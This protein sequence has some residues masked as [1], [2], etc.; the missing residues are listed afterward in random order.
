VTSTVAA[1]TLLGAGLVTP[2]QFYQGLSER[3]EDFRSRPAH[4]WQSPEESS[5]D[6]WYDKYPDYGSGDRSVSYYTSGELV[7]Y[8][9]DLQMR[10]RSQGTK[11]IRD[12]FLWMNDNYAR[13]GTLF[14]QNGIE[15]AAK[16]VI[17]DE[18]S[19]F[20]AANVGHA[21]DLPLEET[22]A[23]AGLKL[24]RMKINTSDPGISVARNSD[25]S[26]VI[27]RV[28][29]ASAWDAG[30]REGD[31]VVEFEGQ[32]VPRRLQSR[33][34]SFPPGAQI[35]LKVRRAGQETA[36]TIPVESRQT[37]RWQISESPNASVKQLARR[38]AW[39]AQ[40]D[41]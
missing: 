9:L 24:E 21:S 35:H 16:R 10:E 6:T 11:G 37:E 3:I 12:L 15:N 14:A 28:S 41:E 40:E 38:K 4:L 26:F 7:G 31:Q 2:E 27:A 25:N 13:K 23:T 17:S 33:I 34:E 36:L 8:A 22:L 32:P 39:L 1:Y 5:L 29:S 19:D 20:F 30:V 18:F